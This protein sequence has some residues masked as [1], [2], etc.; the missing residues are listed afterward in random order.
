LATSAELAR[1]PAR[2]AEPLILNDISRPVSRV[3]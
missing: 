1:G 2:Y 3:L